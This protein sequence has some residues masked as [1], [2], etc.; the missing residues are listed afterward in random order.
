LVAAEYY[1]IANHVLRIEKKS[2]KRVLG[3]SSFFVPEAENQSQSPILEIVTDD[4]LLDR[5]DKPFRSSAYMDTLTELGIKDG[6]YIYR[7]SESGVTQVLAEIRQENGLFRAAV[8]GMDTVRPYN[9]GLALWM[10]FGIAAVHHRTVSVHSSTIVYEGRAVM[11][12]GESGTGKSTQTRLWTQNVAGAEILN[13]DSPFV[14]TERGT[15][16][17]GSPWSGKANYYRNEHYPIAAIVRLR[18]A[19]RNEIRRLSRLEAIGALLPSCT[20]AFAYDGH[21]SS[22]VH[23]IVSDVLSETP[24]Y[25]LDCLPDAAAVRL[26]FDTV[27]GR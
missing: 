1:K 25:M 11:F 18:Q 6:T 27:F 2:L 14:N 26:T 3:F 10:I 22:L 23:G 8:K 4:S 7:Y 17:Y 9:F 12:L 21:L 16:V 20:P 15:L 13:D 19:P 5:M 24:V